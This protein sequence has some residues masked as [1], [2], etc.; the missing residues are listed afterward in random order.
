[1]D[2]DDGSGTGWLGPFASGDTIVVADSWQRG[3]PMAVRCQARDSLGPNPDWSA[4]H[5]TNIS[6]EGVVKWDY[7]LGRPRFSGP[8]VGPDQTIY[9]SCEGGGL[10]ALNPDGTLRWAAPA[11]AWSSP[12]VAADGTIHVLGCPQGASGYYALAYT[13]DGAERWRFPIPYGLRWGAPALG[14]DGTVYVISYADTVYAIN[15][16]GTRRWTLASQRFTWTDFA[17][18]PDGTIYL[19]CGL[20]SLQALN[21]D[22]TVKWRVPAGLMRPA[23]LAI[24]ADGTLYHCGGL[25]GSPWLDAR[26]PDGTPRW[27]CPLPDG[28]ES[29]PVIGPGNTIYLCTEFSGTVAVSPDGVLRWRVPDTENS[30]SPAVRQDGVLYRVNENGIFTA[31][32]PD[33]SVRWKQNLEEDTYAARIAVMPDGTILVCTESALVALAGT[34]PLADSPWPKHGHDLRNTGRVGGR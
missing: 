16:D 22:G 18:A 19:G 14:P 17:I 25:A 30:A 26:D 15:P 7:C 13:P 4:P 31:L 6:A 28:S 11:R 10:L 33:G 34:S 2:W 27:Q 21:P 32:N 8:A 29:S 24:G 20:D 12:V 1:V 23:A 3:G 9:V 5:V